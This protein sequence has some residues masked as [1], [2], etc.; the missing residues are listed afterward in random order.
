MTNFEKILDR[1]KTRKN[2]IYTNTCGKLSKLFTGMDEKIIRAAREHSQ[3]EQ[4]AKNDKNLSQ[5]GFLNKIA[6]SKQQIFEPAQ[7]KYLQAIQQGH[8]LLDAAI[9]ELSTEA[10]PRTNSGDDRMANIALWQVELD[11]A[12]PEEAEKLFCDFANDTD[13]RRLFDALAKNN[14]VCRDILIKAKSHVA[15]STN[16]EKF[17]KIRAWL[18]SM[19]R[20]YI[21]GMSDRFKSMGEGDYNP[22]K[23]AQLDMCLMESLE[24]FDTVQIPKHVLN[25]F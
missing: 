5:Q 25:Q 2:T 12:K 10:N 6:E 4:R 3:N 9:E 1:V 19:P 16:E 14:S 22:N 24:K 15:K 18:N 20:M 7:Q 21:F 23:A 13:F 11:T 8:E 17:T